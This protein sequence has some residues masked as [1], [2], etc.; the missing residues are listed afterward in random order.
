MTSWLHRCWLGLWS[1]LH[2]GFDGTDPRRSALPAMAAEFGFLRVLTEADRKFL[3]LT[4]QEVT[5]RKGNRSSLSTKP[6]CRG[7]VP[8]EAWTTVG[9]DSGTKVNFD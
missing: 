4:D 6:P 2:R 7:G 3:I 9:R 5:S 8:E 1:R